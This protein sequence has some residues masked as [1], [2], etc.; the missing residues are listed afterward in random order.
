MHI[1][2]GFKLRPLGDEFILVGESIELINFNKMITMNEPAAFLWRQV[3]N[4]H[5]FDVDELTKALLDEYEVSEQEA[6][7]DAEQT[8]Q[9]WK[10]AGIIA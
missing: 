2:K 4:G 5:V 9:A 7:Q 1:I 3:E 8:I 6:H 10:N